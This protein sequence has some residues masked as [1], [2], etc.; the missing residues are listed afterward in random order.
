VVGEPVGVGLQHALYGRVVA[1]LR[2]QFQPH[3]R[4]PLPLGPATGER[5]TGEMIA[6]EFLK[7]T[8]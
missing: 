3:R 5:Q 7:R 1:R 2:Q 6:G 4:L 8:T